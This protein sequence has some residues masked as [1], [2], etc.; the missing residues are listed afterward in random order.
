MKVLLDIK[1]I[2]SDPKQRR[3]MIV[4]FIMAMQEHEGRDADR[5]KAEKAY[6]N[7]MKEK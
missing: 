6:D 4:Y 5:E 2:L 7:V 1:K 3:E